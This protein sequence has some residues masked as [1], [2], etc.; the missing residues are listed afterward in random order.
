MKKDVLKDRLKQIQDIEKHEDLREMRYYYKQFT[1][2][3][4]LLSE[5]FNNILEDL[6]IDNFDIK[7]KV[8]LRNGLL[9]YEKDND[10]KANA[11]CQAV[12]LLPP[13]EPPDDDH[14]CQ[15]CVIQGKESILKVKAM[16]NRPLG[17]IFRCSP[18]SHKQSPLLG[19]VLEGQQISPYEFLKMTLFNILKIPRELKAVCCAVEQAT[20]SKYYHKLMRV[21]TVINQHQ[22][23]K[24]GGDGEVVE[25][26]ESQFKRKYRRGRLTRFES[27]NI[28]VLGFTTR[29][30]PKRVF[31]TRVYNRK[32]EN[33]DF[34]TRKVLKPGTILNTDH[35]QV[36][37]NITKRLKEMNIKHQSVNHKL[38]YVDRW[39]KKNHTQNIESRWRWFKKNIKSCQTT[40]F[41]DMYLEAY[42]Y[43]INNLQHNLKNTGRNFLTVLNHV[44]SV[45]P[46]Y[47]D[48]PLTEKPIIPN[49]VK[50][51]SVE[52]IELHRIK[53]EERLKS[54]QELREKIDKELSRIATQF[55]TST[56]DEPKVLAALSVLAKKV[57]L[58]VINQ[59]K[60]RKVSQSAQRR[61]V[62]DVIAK[63]RGSK[64][65]TTITKT[66][67]QSLPTLYPTKRK[68]QISEPS[69]RFTEVAVE[70]CFKEHLTH[71]GDQCQININI[72][73]DF[74]FSTEKHAIIGTGC[75][76][77]DSL[78]ITIYNQSWLNDEFVN[79]WMEYQKQINNR[80]KKYKIGVINSGAWYNF[81]GSRGFMSLNR[82][83]EIFETDYVFFP[84]CTGNH[85]VLGFI[86]HLQK[87]MYVF[88]SL[89][90][91]QERGQMVKEMKE[92]LQRMELLM[93]ANPDLYFNIQH[94][95]VRYKEFYSSDGDQQNDG[96]SCGVLT[97]LYAE[98]LTTG[99]KLK[100]G[101]F[102]TS[103]FMPNQNRISPLQCQR[104]RMAREI[105]EF[106]I[107]NNLIKNG[108][109]TSDV[110]PDILRSFNDTINDSG[111]VCIDSETES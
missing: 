89:W 73:R 41:V 104:L 21:M 3:G 37:T 108:S 50:N 72:I 84:I 76:T 6:N 2:K 61:Q 82:L 57:D 1:Q 11:F 28:W 67:T 98:H 60:G 94:N 100:R 26:D 23:E 31:V 97:C 32:I 106:A 107:T 91:E 16:K 77:R 86:N 92:K 62:A 46:P 42:I 25:A 55:Q 30:E 13:C 66:E 14:D 93:N 45:Y 105:L 74:F 12:G 101:L 90:Q 39:N 47:P 38:N 102:D 17:F 4:I 59:S 79:S 18:F 44:A 68:R 58:P 53:T 65:I 109:H 88:D 9:V 29:N 20:V 48:E 49:H 87:K 64:R 103:R 19:S 27:R 70:E 35:A 24:L 40:D 85:W 5:H 110:D 8:F 15:T 36:Y 22:F 83:K 10:S 75:I 78:A 52:E 43:S 80:S 69:N 95:I 96:S 56:E 99:K 7:F 63:H 81:E 71:C 111:V 54:K 33:V 34:V 51:G